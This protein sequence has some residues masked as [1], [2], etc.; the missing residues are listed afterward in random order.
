MTTIKKE[1]AATYFIRHEKYSYGIF[2]INE[3]GDLFL[4]SDYGMYGF[5]WRAFGDNFK[6]FL[7]T[8]N[9]DYIYDKFDTNARYLCQKGLPKNTREPVKALLDAFREHLKTEL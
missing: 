2:C 9:S 8:T 7:C 6:E 4:N 5:A 3:S 1:Q